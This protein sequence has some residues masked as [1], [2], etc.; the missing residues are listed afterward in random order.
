MKHLLDA[1]HAN[2][3]DGSKILSTAILSRPVQNA[4]HGEEARTW[5]RAI[6]TAPESVENCILTGGRNRKHYTATASASYAA[7]R[8]GC[9]IERAIHVDQGGLWLLTIRGSLTKAVEG[10]IA[11]A[12]W[13]LRH[14]ARRTDQRLR[15][16]ATCEHKDS[17]ANT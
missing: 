11:G 4:L 1:G 15:S 6:V 12:G 8:E 9:A 7:A 13:G 5:I 2:L 3:E 17:H 14:R 10:F 16:A